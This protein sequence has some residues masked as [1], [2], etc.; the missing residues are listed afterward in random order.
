MTAAPPRAQA[1]P[2]RSGV[3]IRAV[4]PDGQRHERHNH[5]RVRDFALV[6]L[7][8]GLGVLSMGAS[9]WSPSVDPNTWTTPGH[10][11]RRE[12]DTGPA[13]PAM[14]RPA[15]VQGGGPQPTV[16]PAVRAAARRRTMVRYVAPRWARRSRAGRQPGMT[17]RPAREHAMERDG[18]IGPATAGPLGAAPRASS[19]RRSPRR[20]RGGRTRKA[21][22]DPP[23]LPPGGTASTPSQNLGR[24]VGRAR[25]PA[26]R[27]SEP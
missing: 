3:R 23:R 9:R 13:T 12:E 21:G 5:A 19:R 24:Q 7:L 2:P 15:R 10:G 16:G 18:R 11:R 8:V 20:R 4:E 1:G 27:R 25:V 17:P 22:A 14:A 26:P 6:G